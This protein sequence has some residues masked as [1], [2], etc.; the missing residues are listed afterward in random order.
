VVVVVMEKCKVLFIVGVHTF[1]EYVEH[2]VE[3]PWRF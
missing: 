1:G 3:D 2:T